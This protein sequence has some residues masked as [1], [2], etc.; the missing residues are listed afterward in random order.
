MADPKRPLKM[1]FLVRDSIDLGHAIL[2]VGHGAVAAHL[3]FSGLEVYQEWLDTSF[4]KVV[5]CVTDTEFE[6]A[7]QF[8]NHVLMTESALEGAET[9]MVFCPREQWPKAFTYY[10]LYRAR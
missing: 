8:D 6:Y 9:C 5:C 7:K 2:S 3:K 1:Y 10:R 4:R